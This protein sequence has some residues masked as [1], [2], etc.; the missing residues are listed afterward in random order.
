[1]RPHRVTCPRPLRPG[2]CSSSASAIYTTSCATL[3][4]ARLAAAPQSV[5]AHLRSVRHVA[6]VGF[7]VHPVLSPAPLA[8]SRKIRGCHARRPWLQ[9]AWLQLLQP[10]AHPA[11]CAA[12]HRHWHLR[13][14]L[15]G[16]TG[17]SGVTLHAVFAATSP[18]MA[19]L[20]GAVRTRGKTE[21]RERLYGEQ[22]QCISTGR[23]LLYHTN[24]GRSRALLKQT[25]APA[26]DEVTHPSRPGELVC[27][28]RSVRPSFLSISTRLVSRQGALSKSAPNT[29]D[30]GRVL[31]WH[32]QDSHTQAACAQVAMAGRGPD[33][34]IPG[35]TSC[36]GS[37]FCIRSRRLAH[38][39]CLSTSHDTKS[40]K[41]T[42][43]SRHVAFQLYC[44]NFPQKSSKREVYCSRVY[45]LYSDC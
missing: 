18:D 6:L 34:L 2:R 16:V 20:A 44:A 36:A 26:Q 39:I 1:M 7:Q 11:W 41:V 35:S 30:K 14:L 21:R 38:H 27:G 37:L 28:C 22:R 8:R 4:P 45:P 33:P 10:R 19:A 29:Q 5:P 42:T 32:I 25:L 24:Q 17:L 3:I 31:I 43:D 13:C 9:H 23:R 15:L 40:S 12:C